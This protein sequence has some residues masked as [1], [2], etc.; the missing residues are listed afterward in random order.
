MRTNK[1][2]KLTLTFALF[3]LTFSIAA[4][5]KTRKTPPKTVAKP[6]KAETQKQIETKTDEVLPAAAKKNSRPANGNT[7]G[8]NNSENQKS[9][10]VQQTAFTYE[11]SQPQFVISSI[12][13][14]HDESGKGRISFRKKDFDEEITDPIQLTNATLE[15]LKTHFEALN[16]LDSTEIYQYENDYSHLGKM[17]IAMQTGGRG[18]I[19]EFNWTTNKNA[20]AIA[21]EYRKISNQYIWMFDITVARQNQPLDAPRLM[22]S[23]DSYL[24]RNEIS[25]PS[26]MIPF[27]K[28]LSDDERIPLIARNNAAR[29]IKEIEKKNK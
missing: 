17:K 9:A 5:T 21:D 22:K 20:K 10:S 7:D 28:D 24:K 16:F 11:F 8:A 1:F 26:Q 18:R 23:F 3:I 27:L 29:I 25:D 14:E 12:R 19:A 4:Q 6:I 13:I 2:F 15:K